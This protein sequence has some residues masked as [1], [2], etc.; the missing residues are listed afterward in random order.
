VPRFSRFSRN[1]YVDRPQPNSA[2]EVR[3]ARKHL[4][5]V[6]HRRA[7]DGFDGANP[8]LV[9][10]KGAHGDAMMI[11]RIRKR[12]ECM[13]HPA[14]NTGQRT[15]PVR[16]PARPG[17][18]RRT[19]GLP[20]RRRA[21]PR[22][23]ASALCCAS[24]E[25]IGS[26][27]PDEAAGARRRMRCLAPQILFLSHHPEECLRATRAKGKGHADFSAWPLFKPATTYSP[28]QFPVQ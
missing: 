28:T 13:G 15:G 14:K 5:D 12:R 1:G 11:P 16:A 20:A 19:D 7:V 18:V 9:L 6:P 4:L 26:H 17:T 25:W 10:G 24:S 27:R 21:R 8:Q 3:H 22:K 2:S 23:L